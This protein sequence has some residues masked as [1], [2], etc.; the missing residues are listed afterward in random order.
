MS[1]KSSFEA[2][3]SVV[4]LASVINAPVGMVRPT[5]NR[6]TVGDAEILDKDTDNGPLTS[7][8]TKVDGQEVSLTLELFDN[9]DK[10]SVR[11]P[12]RVLGWGAILTA[13]SKRTEEGIDVRAFVVREGVPVR[14]GR[15]LQRPLAALAFRT[16]ARHTE[17][18]LAKVEKDLS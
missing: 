9:G 12:V 2:A 16:A 17:A 7:V 18:A 13:V 1:L 4:T 5:G 3:D 8:V 15:L 10:L 11:T 14:V 6:T